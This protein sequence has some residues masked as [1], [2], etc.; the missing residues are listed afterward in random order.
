MRSLGLFLSTIVNI[1]KRR[2]LSI[3]TW[4]IEMD[5]TTTREID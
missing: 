5:D 3:L 4:K 2:K 1:E